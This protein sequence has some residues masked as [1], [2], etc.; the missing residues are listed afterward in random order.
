[1]LNEQ[2]MITSTAPAD[3]PD[4]P[5]EPLT[6]RVIKCL[7]LYGPIYR[8]FGENLILV[9]NR[10][11]ETSL[12]LL[13]L[14]LL[15]LLFTTRATYE[16][17]YTNDL[18]VL[19][20]VIIRN[21][22]D[23][24][25]ELMSLRHTYLRV[26]YP[27]LAHTQLNQPSHYKRD[28]IRK[29]LTLLAGS[30]NAHFAPA[31]ET[32]VRLVDRVSRVPWIAGPESGSEG[33][34]EPTSP[35]SARAAP[36]VVLPEEVSSEENSDEGGRA[37]GEG[38]GSSKL[39]RKM[40]G[41][42]LSNKQSTSNISVVDVAAVQEKP[43]IQTPS[44]N[45]M[46]STNGKEADDDAHVEAISHAQNRG[47]E[48]RHHRHHEHHHSTHRRHGS[49]THSHGHSH[50]HGRNHSRSSR[51]GRDTEEAIDRREDGYGAARDASHNHRRGSADATHY[52]K[53]KTRGIEKKLPPP[54]PRSRGVHKALN[55]S[56]KPSSP[57]KH[58]SS[59]S[60]SSNNSNSNSSPTSNHNHNQAARSGSVHSL[61]SVRGGGGVQINGED[62]TRRD[63]AAS[64][65][66]SATPTATATT[67]G[68]RPRKPLPEVPKHR[69]G[70]PF[71]K[72]TAAATVTT[73]TTVAAA[74]TTTTTTSGA[75]NSSS[76]SSL[77][78][79][80][81]KKQPPKAPPPRRK[82]R[83][84]TGDGTGTPESTG[85]SGAATPVTAGAPGLAP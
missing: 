16:Y 47:R 76:S 69:H 80:A 65:P 56:P 17:F 30:E 55:S 19:V 28:E 75:E 57:L 46:N 71:A 8:T 62:V 51:N 13:I 23:L 41:I 3:E 84:K 39:A 31:D 21:L 2:Y 74:T 67:G 44:R 35:T 38:S 12:Q 45:A 66:G 24:P 15:Y 14:K 53:H 26:L 7:S 49:S 43:G 4:L 59:S 5:S 77:V 40:L 18:C 61:S 33:S 64:T 11:T 1:M 34:S 10:E 82:G 27:L 85:G 63:S 70:T 20:D 81:K 50:S 58:N 79:A 73:T 25:N 9:L 29:V 36:S 6:N 78:A 48:S 22:L 72:T 60:M 42:S 68:R 54:V 52:H 83:L 37:N 32:T